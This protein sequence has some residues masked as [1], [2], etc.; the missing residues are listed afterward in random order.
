M[1]GS[2]LADEKIEVAFPSV[3]Y[4]LDPVPC[5]VLVFG[6]FVAGADLYRFSHDGDI[7]SLDEGG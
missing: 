2:V 7:C 6:A 4:E 1:Y 5:D 3:L